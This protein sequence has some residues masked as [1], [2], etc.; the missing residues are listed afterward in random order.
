VSSP[1]IPIRNG[2]VRT[3]GASWLCTG[4]GNNATLT[5]NQQQQ[6]RNRD[7]PL[8]PPDVFDPHGSNLNRR[9]TIV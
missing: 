1:I 7:M 4:A 2:P 8:V 5:V 9:V 6:K 3:A